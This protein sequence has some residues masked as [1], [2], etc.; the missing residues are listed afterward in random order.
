MSQPVVAVI[1]GA[2]LG[3]RY[4]GSVS[5]PA[6]KITGHALMNMSIEAMAAGGCTHAVVVVNDKVSREL[7]LTRAAMPIP[8]VEVPGGASRQE[9]AHNGLLAV[10]DDP[11]LSGAEIV[12]IHDAVRPMVPAR[13][14]WEVIEAVRGG[15][16]AVAPVI[17]VIDSMRRLDGQ[18]HSE[19]VDR[20]TLRAVQTPQGFPLEVILAAHERMA[21]TGEQFTDDVSCAELAGHEVV[22]VPGSRMSM[23]VTEPTD[24]TI[25]E[26]LWKA[27]ATLGHHSGRRVLRHVPGGQYLESHLA[28]KESAARARMADRAADEDG[29]WVGEMSHAEDPAD[30]MPAARGRSDD[31]SAD[32]T[33]PVTA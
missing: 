32:G 16:E 10:R 19:P 7:G 4:G 1:L 25:A 30:S 8:V 15:A 2:G 13:V 3:L 5:K 27:R 23:K 28:E 6:L 12:L 22:L 18:G 20:S 17:D 11:R 14:V 9:S 31:D 26:A 29:P 24:M 21:S 33:A